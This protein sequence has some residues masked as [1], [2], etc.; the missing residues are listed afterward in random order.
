ME[1]AQAALVAVSMTVANVAVEARTDDGD[2]R[3]DKMVRT[4]HRGR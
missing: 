3:S 4:G 2:N 1:T